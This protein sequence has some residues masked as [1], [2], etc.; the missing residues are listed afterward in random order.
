MVNP[1]SSILLFMYT[2]SFIY[3]GL[4]YGLAPLTFTKV[5]CKSTIDLANSSQGS[6]QS[7]NDIS[8]YTAIAISKCEYLL[9]RIEE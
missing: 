5:D 9:D 4:N 7:I 3:F 1:S 6:E 8:C 2:V